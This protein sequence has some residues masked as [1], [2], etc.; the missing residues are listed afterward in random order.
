MNLMENKN[1]SPSSFNLDEFSK[2]SETFYN[3]IRAKLEAE[4][5]GKYAA[6]DFESEKFW[7]GDT[8][9][10]ALSKAKGEFP[11]K[12]FYLVQ[13]GSP[14]TFT[15]QSVIRDGVSSEDFYGTQWAN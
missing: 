7:I 6:L 14:A 4:Y 8:A 10:G 15:V 1:V 5:R 13:V 11:E 9:S 2:K 3:K 12:L